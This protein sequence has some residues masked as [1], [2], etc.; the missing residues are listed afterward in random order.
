MFKKNTKHTQPDLFG[1]YQQLPDKLQK[2]LR[3]SEESVFY[4]LIFC[5]IREEDFACLYSETGS[6]P[7]APINAMVSSL[8]LQHRH[9]WT[10]EELFDQIE[11]NLLTKTALGLSR[12]DESPFC[13]ASLFNFQNRLS[14]HFVRTGENLLE[15][16]FDHLTSEQLKALK[17]KTNIQ[18]TD[19]FLAASNI[20]N[21]TRLQLL[22][23]LVLRV[24]RILTEADKVHFKNQF[25]DYLGKTSGQ[26]IY[27]LD[28]EDLPHEL[29]KIAELYAWIN[30]VIKPG[31]SDQEIIH[32][33]ERVFAEHFTLV[34]EK[35]QLKNSDELSSECV[36]SPDDLE[37]TYRYKNHTQNQGQSINVVETAHPENPL[38]LI[39][40]VSVHPNNKDDS[41]ILDERVDRLQEKTPDLDELHFDG[42]YGS[43]PVDN[44]LDELGITGI[45]TAVRGNR[46][47]V[48]ITIEQEP[49]SR[50]RVKCPNQTVYSSLARKRH[51]ANFDLAVCNSCEW[52]EQCPAQIGKRYRTFYFTHKEYLSKRRQQAIC[53]LPENRRR[54]RAN[55]E[56][57]VREFTHKMPQRK[58]KVRGFFKT[59]IFAYSNAVS[60]NFGRIYRYLKENPEKALSLALKSFSYVKDQIRCLYG[61]VQNNFIR[62][63]KS[64]RYNL[65]KRKT[66]KLETF[67]ATF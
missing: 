31:Y 46:C 3:E 53:H 38:N 63:L 1:F 25:S 26:Y 11:F 40:D 5:R 35:I 57:T 18:R 56:A 32:T 43:E 4:R 58:L 20:R 41:R 7:N 54:L 66:L 13:A 44:K 64:N 51:K 47:E 6:R 16:V 10:F 50:Y 55:I 15:K 14:Q 52:K 37:A 28:A 8:F 36:Q 27:Q 67:I 61:L 42:G 24:F 62:I 9:G 49:D 23:E 34:E 45:Q 48:E 22:I 29:D 12:L 17:I 60:I 33:F 65:Y 59:C 19:S 21:Y 39:D 30:Q 2:R